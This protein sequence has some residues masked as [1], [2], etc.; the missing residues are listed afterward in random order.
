MKNK[1]NY[2]FAGSFYAY[3]PQLKSTHTNQ[4]VHFATV[5]KFR[6][7]N[8]AYRHKSRDTSNTRIGVKRN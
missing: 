8:E 5:K 7:K 3:T 4:F 2:V 1:I 6:E